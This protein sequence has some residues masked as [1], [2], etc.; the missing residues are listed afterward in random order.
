MTNRERIA[1]LAAGAA[2]FEASRQFDAGCGFPSFWDHTGNSVRLVPLYTYGRTRVQL[3]CAACG[4]HLGH[5]F[6]H[7]H[8][9]T[10]VRYCIS[11][12]GICFKTA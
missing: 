3:L 9:P 10:K 6:A 5:L 8:T 1:A 12:Q 7:K 11:Q 2:L 4:Q